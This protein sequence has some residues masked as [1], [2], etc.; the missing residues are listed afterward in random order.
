MNGKKKNQLTGKSSKHG[1]KRIKRCLL[2]KQKKPRQTSEEQ[3]TKKISQRNTE[4][5]RGN[6]TWMERLN[7]QLNDT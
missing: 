4:S 7:Q 5:N 1:K 3:R 6:T 2:S